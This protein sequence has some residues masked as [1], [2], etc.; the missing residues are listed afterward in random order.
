MW[1]SLFPSNLLSNSYLH[2]F[3]NHINR[4]KPLKFLPG[5]P[6]EV[7]LLWASCPAAFLPSDT[8]GAC[9]SGS[10]LHWHRFPSMELVPFQR[11]AQARRN[12]FLALYSQKWNSLAYG[13]SLLFFPNCKT[14][15][16]F[17]IILI[18]FSF[19]NHSSCNY[20]L[21]SS[22]VHGLLLLVIFI[23]YHTIT[24]I[25]F[26]I[27]EQTLHLEV[28]PDNKYLLNFTSLNYWNNNVTLSKMRQW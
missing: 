2:P 20:P 14:S 1:L 8:Q 12:R 7:L 23:E 28:A 17:S 25:I 6:R 22:W 15:V 13:L 26:F 19:S 9:F 5:V 24:C 11:A 10:P 27:W 4:G 3:S 21:Y 16:L 18:N